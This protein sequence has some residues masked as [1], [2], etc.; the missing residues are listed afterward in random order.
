M[1]MMI[2][3]SQTD[4]TQSLLPNSLQHDISYIETT[5]VSPL[6]SMPKR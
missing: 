2:N 5:T 1:S 3:N 6:S 4:L